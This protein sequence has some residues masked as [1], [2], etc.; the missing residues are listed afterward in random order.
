MTVERIC[1]C[2]VDTARRDESTQ[3][4]A[5]RMQDRNV[6]TLIVLDTDDRPVGIVTVRDLA[7]RVV[8]AAVDPYATTVG[9]VM[10]AAPRTVTQSTPI[11]DALV[12]MRH[13]ACRRLPVV[14]ADGRLYGLLSLDDVL[15]LLAEEFAHVAKLLTAESPEMLRDWAIE[16]WAVPASSRGGSAEAYFPPSLK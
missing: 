13:H 6:G 10:T 9:E 2:E 8:A 7:I 12:I 5:R 15:S 11:E 3:A 1:T 4:A 14:N 16:K